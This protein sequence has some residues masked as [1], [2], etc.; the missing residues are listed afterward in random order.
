MR[1]R[2]G[3]HLWTSKDQTLPFAETCLEESHGMWSMGD[4][5]KIVD[6][7][8]SLLPSSRIV[9]PKVQKIKPRS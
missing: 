7:G 3:S 6:F 2:V 5:G 9:H 8:G 4:P 1:Q